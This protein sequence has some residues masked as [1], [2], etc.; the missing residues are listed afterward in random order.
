MFKCFM[1]IS[2][3]FGFICLQ[4]CLHFLRLFLLILTSFLLVFRNVT[5]FM[6]MYCIRSPNIYFPIPS[7]RCVVFCKIFFSVR[8][9]S[10][11]CRMRQLLY[12][13]QIQFWQFIPVI[14]NLST[15]K[16]FCVCS[17][18]TTLP[19][20]AKKMYRCTKRK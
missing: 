3:I 13:Q 6:C 15:K 1:V 14:L 19:G 8:L 18:E 2:R 16:H 4:S 9:A 17:S 20:K 5:S 7:L 10:Q 12:W 11:T